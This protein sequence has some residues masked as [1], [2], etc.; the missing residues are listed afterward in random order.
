MPQPTTISPISMM[1]AALDSEPSGRRRWNAPSRRLEK[2]DRTCCISTKNVVVLMPPPVE[3]GDAPMNIKIMMTSR[4]ALLMLPKSTLEKPAV[5]A[6]MLWKSAASQPMWS[7]SCKSTAPPTSSTAV[8][9][10]TTL[11]WN[12]ILRNCP[13]Q[14]PTS[15]MTMKPMPPTMTSASVTRF[16]S[17]SF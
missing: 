10:S 5:R 4:P 2:M 11:V 13:R 15:R 3:P 1:V 7:V 17:R 14:R 8:V 6:V 16:S 12:V 9:E